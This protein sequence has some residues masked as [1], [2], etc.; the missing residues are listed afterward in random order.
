[1]PRKKTYN[2][3]ETLPSGKT[4]GVAFFEILHTTLGSDFENWHKEAS[5]PEVLRF[6]HTYVFGQDPST[7]A[8]RQKGAPQGLLMRVAFLD[9]ASKQSK[10]TKQHGAY[11]AALIDA[12]KA[13]VISIDQY[14]TLKG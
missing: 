10:A 11:G 9:R 6:C 1:M 2:F 8:F 3:R 5:Y 4:T 12:L 13:G 7:F 14:Y